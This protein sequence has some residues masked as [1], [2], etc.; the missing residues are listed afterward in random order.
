MMKTKKEDGKIK[1]RVGPSLTN[2]EELH[3]Y[4]E[5]F[6]RWLSYEIHSERMSIKQAITELKIDQS[7]VYHILKKYKPDLDITLPVMTEAEK[8]K[9]EKQEQ[10]IKE[11]EKKLEDAQ[12]KNIALE[13]LI[14]VAEKQLKV[15]IRKK[16]GAKQ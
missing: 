5:S 9:L 8:K 11:L 10:R 1:H 15:P 14:D 7:A 6:R 3:K 12:I 2:K 4:E 16:P 13:T